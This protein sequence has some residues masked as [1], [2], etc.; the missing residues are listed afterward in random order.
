MFFRPINKNRFLLFIPLVLALTTAA[1]GADNPVR[2]A[3]K[4]NGL[5]N[6][7]SVGG[8]IQIVLQGNPTTGYSWDLAS[9][10]TNILRQIAKVEYRQ[11]SQPAGREMVGV[12]GEFVFRFKAIGPGP[13]QVK[14]IY[15]R[16]WE[17]TSFDKAYSAVIEVK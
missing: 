5:T 17:T 1:C 16:P 2:L 8:E 3:E 14:L 12:G 7:V 15:R 11:A 13:G 6:A 4:D 10:S 9:F